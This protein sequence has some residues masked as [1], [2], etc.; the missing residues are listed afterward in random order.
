M[1]LVAS[2]NIGVIQYVES[3]IANCTPI[4]VLVYDNRAGLAHD[5]LCAVLARRRLPT[6][7]TIMR[8]TM[9]LV[10]RTG[11]YDLRALDPCACP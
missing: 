6:I 4:H 11:P 8:R 7:C 5:S 1:Y 10:P 2:R 9:Q 3:T